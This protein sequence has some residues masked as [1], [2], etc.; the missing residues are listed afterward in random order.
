MPRI[1]SWAVMANRM[2][3]FFLR[4]RGTAIWFMK[5]SEEWHKKQANPSIQV[6]SLSKFPNYGTV[7]IYLFLYYNLL[8]YLLG[9][10]P[11]KGFPLFQE[12]ANTP[13]IL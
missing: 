9:E 1:Q 10:R 6:V 4:P 2:A 3:A 11:Q 5:N 7:E 8:T 13:G 12:N